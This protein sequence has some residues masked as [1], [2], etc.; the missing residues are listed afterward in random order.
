[1]SAGTLA[2]PE[3]FHR[4]VRA[5]DRALGI[6][7]APYASA[8]LFRRLDSF[9]HRHGIA[10]LAGLARR[11]EAEPALGE[12][13]AAF[14]TINVTEFFRN[15][16]Q[17]AALRRLLPSLPLSPGGGV[18]A[19]SAG[20]SIGAEPYSLA[21]LLREALPGRRHQ[22]LATD[23]DADALAQAEAGRY[24]AE[25]VT[26]VPDDLK[27]RYLRA[28]DGGFTV[29]EALRRMVRFQRHDLLRDPPPGRFDLVLCRNVTI[30]FNAA[31]RD[32]VYRCLSQSLVEGGLLF[33][34]ATESLLSP[35]PYGL[36][37]V[38][39]GFYR[40]VAA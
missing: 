35:A 37:P 3:G 36:S 33:I 5:V 39:P 19:W 17:W 40:K 2:V 26:G 13:F 34:G 18:R 8:Q 7:L 25:Q 10:D 1:M 11:L 28:E 30:Y 14:L 15:P 22:V 23:I 4:L 6:D 16:Q 31:G 12:A 29:V 9:C 27:S 20:C 32:R 21:M 38:E 24:T